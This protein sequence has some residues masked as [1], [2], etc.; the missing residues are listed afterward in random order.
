[1]WGKQQ[2]INTNS[3]F[4]K[5]NNIFDK[6]SKSAYGRIKNTLIDLFTPNERKQYILPKIV[7]IG[8]ESAGKSSLLE[9][10][11]KCQ[12]FPRDSKQ[13][14]KCP[15]HVKLTQGDIL[16][17]IIYTDSDNKVKTVE[18]K[19]KSCIYEVVTQ[20]MDNLNDIS[21]NELTINIT[22]PDMISFEFYDLPG[23]VSYP[24]DNAVLTTN[25]C[26]KYISNKNSIVLCV[27][28]ATTTRLTSCQS[29]S[30]ITEMKMEQ[31]CILALTMADRVQAENIEE[32]IIKRIIKTSDEITDLNF[33]GYIAVV[34]RLHYNRYNLED[35]ELQ[36]S[37]WFNTNILQ[38]I[39]N[40]Y[41]EHEQ[42]IRHN[43]TITNLIIRIDKLYTQFIENEWKPKIL[44]LIYQQLLE[45][46]NDNERLGDRVSA[47]NI[48]DIN[49]YIHSMIAS[50]YSL[51]KE[52]SDDDSEDSID[53]DNKEES[54]DNKKINIYY[55]KKYIESGN[56]HKYIEYVNEHV[57]HFN[58]IC[59]PKHFIY[60]Y[61]SNKF[62]TDTKY[63]LKRFVQLK[64]HIVSD[65][66]YRAAELL[67]TK[68][69][70]IIQKT[71]DY[72]LYKYLD[73]IYLYYI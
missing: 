33:A 26:R 16:Y 45:L 43:I 68:I 38:Y 1:M 23:I 31:N 20:Y 62:M 2:I 24:P 66:S 50:C 64:E 37:K 69:P 54:V 4:F 60:E 49:K 12:L 42:T 18:L 59:D 34:N 25:L 15:I 14:T 63:E 9:N 40:E 11:T 44:K 53:S 13:C 8:N 35:H 36:E 22:E 27:V 55:S 51:Y 71:K 61:I 3:D 48:S 57:E 67:Q 5:G 52:D 56:Y 41:I 39:P 32:L 21:E 10:I 6:L 19:S 30:L 17:S 7:V 65:L 29:I 47:N 72:L 73:G 28:P 58:Y 46:I 70:I